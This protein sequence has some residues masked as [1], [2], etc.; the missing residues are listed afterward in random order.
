MNCRNLRS[1]QRRRCPLL[2][3]LRRRARARLPQLRAAVAWRRR[4]LRWL[5]A[6]G[7][8]VHDARLRPAGPHARSPGEEDLA[9]PVQAAGRTPDRNRALRRRRRLDGDGRTARPGA[10]IQDHP[11]RRRLHGGGR[12]SLRGSHHPVPRRRHHGPVRGPDRPRERRPSRGR[13][14]PGDAAIDST[15]TP[16]GSSGSTAPPCASASG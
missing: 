2:Y 16:K 9:G 6:A 5:R 14:R 15:P 13:R 4:R 11:G 1:S 7:G 12:P 3:A 8:R 10:D